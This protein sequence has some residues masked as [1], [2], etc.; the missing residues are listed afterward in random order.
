[1]KKVKKFYFSILV[2]LAFSG[3]VYYAGEIVAFANSVRWH[4]EGHPLTFV[5]KGDQVIKQTGIKIGGYYLENNFHHN[6]VLEANLESKK[7]CSICHGKKD[8]SLII[9]MIWPWYHISES[10]NLAQR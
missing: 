3:S 6:L 10:K 4:N 2:V 9:K 8:K 1:M 5:V 7:S